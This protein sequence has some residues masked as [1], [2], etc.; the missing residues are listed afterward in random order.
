M[1]DCDLIYQPEEDD[2]ETLGN[3]TQA[4]LPPFLA[5]QLSQRQSTEPVIDLGPEWEEETP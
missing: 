2:D 1:L 5:S 3:T 4:S